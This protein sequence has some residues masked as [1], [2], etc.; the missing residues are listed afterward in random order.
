[1]KI[2]WQKNDEKMHFYSSDFQG[3][4]FGLILLIII[5]EFALIL[6]SQHARIYKETDQQISRKTGNPIHLSIWL[7]D[8]TD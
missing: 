8:P 3:V 1:M 2:F 6:G 5:Y 7:S 4:S